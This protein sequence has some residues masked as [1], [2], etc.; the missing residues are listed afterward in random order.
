MGYPRATPKFA[1]LEK[2]LHNVLLKSFE[3]KTTK[4]RPHTR[5]HKKKTEKMINLHY[6]SRTASVVTF[7]FFFFFLGGIFNQLE[8]RCFF[9]NIII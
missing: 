7:Q 1:D 9:N 4:G 8:E 5:T 6:I 2:F 3:R